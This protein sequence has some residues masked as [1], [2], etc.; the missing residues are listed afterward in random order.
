M[1][2]DLR[3]ASYLSELLK[4]TE[5][6]HNIQ[7][8]PG[9]TWQLEVDIV[10]FESPGRRGLRRGG[11]GCSLFSA[12]LPHP[13]HSNG[14]RGKWEREKQTKT[15]TSA[16]KFICLHYCPELETRDF[17]MQETSAQDTNGAV[18]GQTQKLPAPDCCSV[19]CCMSPP[20]GAGRGCPAKRE[21]GR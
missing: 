15:R 8:H 17:V 4:R 12:P 3:Q 19:S 1:V 2:W 21:E 13:H 7:V 20:A 11:W 18:A 14:R 6:A 10:S 5:R 16:I 9:L